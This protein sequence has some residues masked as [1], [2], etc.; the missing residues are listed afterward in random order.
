MGGDGGGCC[1][2]NLNDRSVLGLFVVFDWSQTKI[3]NDE[4]Q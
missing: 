3:D 1:E 2:R 4:D